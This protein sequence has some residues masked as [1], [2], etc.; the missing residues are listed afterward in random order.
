M[1]I[2]STFIPV[3]QKECGPMAA[4]DFHKDF[5]NRILINMEQ[6]VLDEQNIQAAQNRYAMFDLFANLY[7]KE[8]DQALLAALRDDKFR[9]ALENAGM[10]LD[11]KFFTQEISELADE[12]AV[13]FAQLFLVP[14]SL[15]SPHESVQ[16]KNGSGILRGPETT[17]VKRYYENIGFKIRDDT[18]MEADHI[19]I[20]LEFL[21]HLA[22]IETESLLNNQPEKAN[23]AQKYQLDFLNNHLGLWVYDFLELIKNQSQTVFYSELSSLASDFI[24]EQQ[25]QLSEITQQKSNDN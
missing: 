15:K 6:T 19:S 18:A 20:E 23:D 24:S 5:D 3:K 11:E 8:P 21:V 17:K 2:A 16:I 22:Q 1:S 14:G 4:S 9:S 12:L 7:R 10:N 25:L 13:D